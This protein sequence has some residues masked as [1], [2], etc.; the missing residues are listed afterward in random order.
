MYTKIADKL[1]QVSDLLGNKTADTVEFTNENFIFFSKRNKAHHPIYN[2]KLSFATCSHASDPHEAAAS[3]L[4]QVFFCTTTVNKSSWNM[5]DFSRYFCI[6]TFYFGKIIQL[7]SWVFSHA[8]Q[9]PISYY[10][11]QILRLKSSGVLCTMWSE[12]L[13]Q[14]AQNLPLILNVSDS[15]RADLLHIH[16]ELRRVHKCKYNNENKPH[17]CF[18]KDC[19]VPDI[20]WRKELSGQIRVKN[21]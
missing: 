18:F 17:V 11:K 7:H 12:S 4:L 3:C 20:H 10:R 15:C 13:V 21:Q 1:F 2:T 9:W 8:V 16:R 5:L 14:G 19:H 6:Q